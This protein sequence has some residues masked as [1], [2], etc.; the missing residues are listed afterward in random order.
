MEDFAILRHR[1]E[2][3][4]F[5]GYSDAQLR[6]LDPWIRFTPFLTGLVT[7]LSTIM[8]SPFILLA[9]AAVLAVGV[10]TPRHPFDVLYNR[11]IRLLEESPRLPVTPRRRRLVYALY[12]GGL[13]LVA[14]CFFTGHDNWGMALG[15]S[16][17]MCKGWTAAHQVCLPSEALHRLFGTPGLRDP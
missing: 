6:T 10:L 7:A 14:W 3:Q 15:W 9:L 13:L 11:A 5:T 8:A 1:I 4:G 16:M 12:C 17:A 2:V